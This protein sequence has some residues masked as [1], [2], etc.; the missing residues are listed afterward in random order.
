MKGNTI[1]LTSNPKGLFLEGI[2]G[3]TSLPGTAMQLKTSTDAI[4]GRPTWVAANIGTDGAP[5]GIYILRE[6]D[7]QGKTVSDAY[8]NGTR[9][10]LYSPIA[11]EELNIRCGEGA[12]TSN[13]FNVGDKLM[14]DSDT[15]TFIPTSG[16]PISNPF[17]VLEHD[18]QIA[19]NTL[20][21][22]MYTGH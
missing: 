20:V 13:T 16:S 8:V 19:A 12:G 17:Q 6:D 11:G 4:G 18:V 9:C 5:A 7:L 3:D 1:V 10:F 14:L 15:G 22:C 21:W 2:I